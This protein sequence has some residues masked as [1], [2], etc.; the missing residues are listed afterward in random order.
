MTMH[1]LCSK[2]DTYDL[3]KTL[4]AS[5][6]LIHIKFKAA[7]WCQKFRRD[8]CLVL[9]ASE[10]ADGTCVVMARSLETP[11]CPPSTQFTRAHLYIT[12]AQPSL[13]GADLLLW[14]RMVA[15]TLG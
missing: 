13:Q 7:G 15:A 5:T 2:F 10:L 6:R 9:F 14:Q 12:C 1:K 3:L 11:L 8:F 4:N